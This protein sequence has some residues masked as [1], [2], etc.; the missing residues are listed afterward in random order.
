MPG[1]FIGHFGLDYIDGFHWKI[2]E[3]LQ[4]DLGE[5][6]SNE[7]VIVPAGYTTDFHSIP[8]PLWPIFPPAQYGKSSVVHDYLCE[9][10]FITHLRDGLEYHIQPGDGQID[11]IYRESLEVE[12]CG[13]IKR[14]SMWLGVRTNH[15]TKPLQFWR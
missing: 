4:F 11:A 7:F 1:K 15:L 3:E 6:G 5:L 12:G 10:G 14:Y 9:G 8:R 2:Q 13:K